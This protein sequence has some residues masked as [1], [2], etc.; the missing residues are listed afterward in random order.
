MM[1]QNN[2]FQLIELLTERNGSRYVHFLYDFYYDDAKE[3]FQAD[4]PAGLC[5]S[6]EEMLT[7]KYREMHKYGQYNLNTLYIKELDEEQLQDYQEDYCQYRH[8]TTLGDLFILPE[9][10]LYILAY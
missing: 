5:I 1:N 8:I 2:A 3:C 10:T 4:E 6:V 7:K 9:N